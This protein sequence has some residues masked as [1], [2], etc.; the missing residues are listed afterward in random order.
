MKTLTALTLTTALATLAA[1][2]FAQS[3]GDMT[4][5][6]GLGYIEPTDSYSTTGAGPLRADGNARPTLTFEYFFADRV[7]LEVLASWPFE[8]DIEL[9]GTGDVAETKHLPPTVSLQY[10]FDTGSGITPFVGAGVNYTYFFDERGNGAL[11]GTSVDLDDSWG[12]A[13]HGGVDFAITETSALRLDVRYI[14]IE[15]DATVGG[16]SIGD[17]EIDPWVVGAAYVLKF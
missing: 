9:R 12:L 17:V 4:L 7:G 5:G 15:T 16:A 6:L 2:A 14:D 10:H 1:P 13:L 3:Q 11:A 8:H